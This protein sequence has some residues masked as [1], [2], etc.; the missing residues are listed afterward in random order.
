ME[1][2]QSELGFLGVSVVPG[3]R[4]RPELCGRRHSGEGGEIPTG[5]QIPRAQLLPPPKRHGE[6]KLFQT[7]LLDVLFSSLFKS[8][9]IT[10][11]LRGITLLLSNTSVQ[12]NTHTLL[13]VDH[14][15]SISRSK[16]RS[17]ILKVGV[18]YRPEV[19]THL[20]I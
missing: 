12:I 13:K 10:L 3:Q 20:W 11:A 19:W 5:R 14:E 17:Y 16:V 4:D 18:R 2:E 7:Q 1:A 6:R 15:Q 9:F 8:L